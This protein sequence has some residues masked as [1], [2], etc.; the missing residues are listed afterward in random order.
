VGVVV[1]LLGTHSA[2][3]RESGRIEFSVTTGLTAPFVIDCV[4]T[5]A[6]YLRHC[7][8]PTLSPGDIVIIDNLSAH[9]REEVWKRCARIIEAARATLRYLPP[10]SPRVSIG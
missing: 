4:M 2:S 5:R 7:L 9:K 6:I 3:P 8:V 1:I 10:Y